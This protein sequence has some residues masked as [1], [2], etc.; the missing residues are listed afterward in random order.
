M[1]KRLLVASIAVLSLASC[2]FGE[3]AKTHLFS[4]ECTPAGEY[5]TD[6]S[7]CCSGECGEDPNPRPN[8]N[9][10]GCYCA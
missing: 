2:S 6:P 8:V 5:D 10:P 7:N 4:P 9:Y 1:F 3:D